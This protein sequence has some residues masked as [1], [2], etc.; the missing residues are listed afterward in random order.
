M[1]QKAKLNL[2]GENRSTHKIDCRRFALKNYQESV[3]QCIIA[4]VLLLHFVN[5]LAG[6]FDFEWNP[7]LFAEGITG[8]GVQRKEQTNT[9]SDS[10]RS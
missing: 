10:I 3:M 5:H 9:R 7:G 2:E 4:R 8:V 1:D 6:C